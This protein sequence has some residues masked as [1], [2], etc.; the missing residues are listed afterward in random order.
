MVL[1]S[2][3]ADWYRKGN[4]M[5][6]GTVQKVFNLTINAQSL[7][8]NDIDMLVDYVNGKLGDDL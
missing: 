6:R 3:E 2:A 8:Q 4:A 7:S 1:T 5:G